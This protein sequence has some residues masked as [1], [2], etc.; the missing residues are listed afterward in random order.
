MSYKTEENT[1]DASVKSKEGGIDRAGHA[2]ILKIIEGEQDSGWRRERDKD[3]DFVHFRQRDSAA[4][5]ML[6]HRGIKVKPIDNF[7]GKACR[8]AVSIL[9][10]NKKDARIIASPHLNPDLCDAI[11]AKLEVAEDESFCDRQCLS[12][13]Y[14]QGGVGIAWLEVHRNSNI[15]SN[16]YKISEAP[17]NE[18]FRDES[19]PLPEYEDG[20]WMYQRKYVHWEMAAALWPDKAKKIKDVF[21]S[22]GSYDWQPPE[23]GQSTGLVS[24]LDDYEFWTTEEKRWLDRDSGFI[25]IGVAHTKSVRNGLVLVG[26]YSS[27]PFD[28]ENEY[29]VDTIISGES[30]L[31]E[32][33]IT[34]MYR[35]FFAGPLKLGS[36]LVAS[37]KFPYVPFYY[38]IDGRTGFPY[39]ISRFMMS[40]QEEHN[41]RSANDLWNLG[42]MR[43]RMT[44]DAVAM[45][46]DEF[47]SGVSRPDFVC[48]LNRQ[49]MKDGGVYEE[50]RE[51]ELSEEQ[52]KRAQDL[53]VAMN[54]ASGTND[55]K[56]GYQGPSGNLDF[57][58]PGKSLSLLIANHE[59]SRMAVLERLL[60][61]VLE[62]SLEEEEVIIPERGMVNEKRVMINSPG[63]DGT[64]RNNVQEFRG[65]IRLEDIPSSPER[66]RSEMVSLSEIAKSIKHEGMQNIIAPYVVSYSGIP[67][68]NALAREMKEASGTPS[69]EDIKQR[70]DEAV[71]GALLEAKIEQGDRKL[72]Q[73]DRKLDL[74]EALD[75][76]DITKK[77]AEADLL[78]IKGTVEKVEEIYSAMQAAMAVWANKEIAPVG[79]QI[80]NSAGFVDDD[81]APVI[82]PI[83]PTGPI[84]GPATVAAPPL[85]PQSEVRQ[86]TSPLHPPRTQS[87][88]PP[89][90]GQNTTERDPEPGVETGIEAQ[91]NQII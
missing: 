35:T 24:S 64:I 89:A 25:S 78:V 4:L 31:V 81:L 46:I 49:E 19:V 63:D 61:F 68:K 36:E 47:R 86:N 77:E 32:A 5:Q 56:E 50:K 8:D 65:K 17:R 34:E 2:E 26:K 10:E 72:G 87:T 12:V 42:S 13:G 80:L 21:E 57:V 44:E 40:L 14:K 51:F 1:S 91:G 33:P 60:D 39:G 54:E 58:A 82:V 66:T 22:G 9:A 52:Y 83:G 41:A 73:D 43:I 3:E 90:I 69:E 79:Q 67:D 20:Q 84:S 38:F 71:K 62:D 6:E 48:V 7:I 45:P 28:R 29:H 30:K 37:G 23:G 27:I 70:I 76:A 18:L 16:P 85:P 53:R 11:S 59:Y 75:A 88:S 74:Q 55:A 15:L